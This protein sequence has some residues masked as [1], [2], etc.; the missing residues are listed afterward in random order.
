M[1]LKPAKAPSNPVG[2]AIPESTETKVEQLVA[3]KGKTVPTW[4]SIV[5]A[6]EAIIAAFEEVMNA[7]STTNSATVAPKKKVALKG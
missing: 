3:L 5:K 1:F 7:P 2:K 6:I 4:E